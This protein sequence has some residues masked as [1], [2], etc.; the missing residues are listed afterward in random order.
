MI[1]KANTL[2]KV[3]VKQENYLGF[4][5]N[6][7]ETRS[8]TVLSCVVAAT[9]K[10]YV[11]WL[12]LWPQRNIY[13]SVALTRYASF[14]EMGNYFDLFICFWWYFIIYETL[15]T[16][17]KK[18]FPSQLNDIFLCCRKL[19]KGN[20]I[21]HYAFVLLYSIIQGK[22]GAAQILFPNQSYRDNKSTTSNR[23]KCLIVTAWSSFFAHSL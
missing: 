12:L 22:K 3:Y 14:S 6:T 18:G 8:D 1:F 21:S 11:I 9:V 13:S 17:R 16:R 20:L 19:L 4:Y 5:I 15:Q 23:T 10:H 2:P 7:W